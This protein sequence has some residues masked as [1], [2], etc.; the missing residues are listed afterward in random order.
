VVGKITNT[1]GTKYLTKDSKKLGEL[2]AFL[3]FF[4]L[5]ENQ[6]YTDKKHKGLKG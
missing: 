3:V 4:V 1:K 6:G 5:E 2:C